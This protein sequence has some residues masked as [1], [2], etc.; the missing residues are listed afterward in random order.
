M[1][2]INIVFIIA[3]M[4][5]SDP[6]QVTESNHDYPILI[7][8]LP[9]SGLSYLYYLIHL[10]TI[11]PN[12]I[13]TGNYFSPLS[14]SSWISFIYFGIT[15]SIYKTLF[16]RVTPLT[17][18]AIYYLLYSECVTYCINLWIFLLYFPTVLQP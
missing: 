4:I 2:L 13:G 18:W 12:Y 11:F 5:I 9:F 14:I 17:N 15:I 10:V 8:Q 3:L 1:E 7:W 6:F 16:H